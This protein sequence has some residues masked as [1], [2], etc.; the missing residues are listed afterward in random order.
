MGASYFLVYYFKITENLN[1]MAQIGERV[2]L[3]T[4][5]TPHSINGSNQI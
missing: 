5:E 3:S 2:S 4:S 1:I